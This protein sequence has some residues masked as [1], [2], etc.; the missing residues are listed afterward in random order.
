MCNDIFDL[1]TKSILPVLPEL[2]MSDETNE[3]QSLGSI[4]YRLFYFEQV[5]PFTSAVFDSINQ[6]QDPDTR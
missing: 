2:K 5:S 3:S 6:Q 4:I 1:P